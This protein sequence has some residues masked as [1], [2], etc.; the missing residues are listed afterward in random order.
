MLFFLATFSLVEC[1]PIIS[2]WSSENC[3]GP[4]AVFIDWFMWSIVPG[5]NTSLASNV[6]I[7]RCGAN[8]LPLIKPS[9]YCIT[10]VILNMMDYGSTSYFTADSQFK[11]NFPAGGNIF[12]YCMLAPAGASNV[13]HLCCTA[14][15]SYISKRTGIRLTFV[16]FSMAT[17]VLIPLATKLS[18][19]A[20]NT[21]NS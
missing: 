13:I 4:P 8:L 12:N 1:S 14:I 5:Q 9:Q 11:N 17:C 18:Q 19:P 7:D 6:S 2:L 15:V 16:L 3:V 10:P 20:L 21:S